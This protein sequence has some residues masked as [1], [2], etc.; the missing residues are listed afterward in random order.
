MYKLISITA[1]LF[2]FPLVLAAQQGTTGVAASRSAGLGYA[3]AIST[4]AGGP[5]MPLPA[6]GDQDDPAYNT[7]KEGY[8]CV[9]DGKW[10]AARKKFDE[11]IK[12]YPK[13]EYVDEARYWTAYAFKHTDRKKA[14]EAYT[15]FIKDFPKSKYYDDAVADLGQLDPTVVVSTEMSGGETPEHV[16]Q[17][18]VPRAYVS[19]KETFVTIPRMPRGLEMRKLERSLARASRGLGRGVGAAPWVVHTPVPDEKVDPET[20][21]KMDALYA[22]GETQE[23]SGS[24]GA[25]RD[26]VLDNSQAKELRDAAMDALS[27]FKKYDVLSVYLDVAKKDTSEEMQNAAIDYIGQITE[28]KGRAIE[29]LTELFKAIPQHR[30]EQLETVMSSIAEI[31]GDR[32][33]E[34]LSGVA[35]SNANYELRSQAVYYLGSIGGEKARAALYEILRAR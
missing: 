35:R 24:F 1:M 4:E 23:D 9:L 20:R 8:A 17:V 11:I 34:F 18:P 30:T 28:N 31:G 21:L 16:M 12:K 19:G 29:T 22:L 14:I 25:L 6:T 26:V 2:A 5:D 15:L 13:S 7:Y 10:D 3:Y 33:V 27:N 32:S